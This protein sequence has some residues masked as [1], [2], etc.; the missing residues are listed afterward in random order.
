MSLKF[1]NPFITT[2]VY[3][4]LLDG[5]VFKK[6]DVI[7]LK[8]EAWK[9]EYEDVQLPKPLDE[10][11][12][13]T[14]VSKVHSDGSIAIYF[15]V[16]EVEMNVFPRFFVD[17]YLTDAEAEEREELD[18]CKV[19]I[20]RKAFY[21]K[22]DSSSDDEEGIQKAHLTSGNKKKAPLP[23]GR[24][25]KS[26]RKESLDTSDCE[27]EPEDQGEL[28]AALEDEDVEEVDDDAVTFGALDEEVDVES[29]PFDAT[30]N[31]GN[32]KSLS[33]F[34]GYSPF[35]IFVELFIKIIECVVRCTNALDDFYK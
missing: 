23:R 31:R 21:A 20:G 6:E 1:V 8:A 29:M 4:F 25:K 10:Y 33:R 18:M 22:D 35:R 17:V 26:P 16:D 9:T 28:D 15:T 12:L 32:V 30:P 7:W 27:E 2:V 34:D 5:L 11:K 19:D 3:T 14:E 24:G 13:Y